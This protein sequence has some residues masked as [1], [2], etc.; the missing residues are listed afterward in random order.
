MSAP[1]WLQPKSE[2]E[3]QQI[4]A[5]LRER[6]HPLYGTRLRGLYLYGSYARGDAREG[7]DLDVLVILDRLE[8]QWS[9]IQRTSH[10][11]AA[12]SLDHDVSIAT[13]FTSEDR[14]QS[15]DSEFLRVVR[16][17]GRAA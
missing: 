15:A 5:E 17:E 2:A 16:E 7:S 4:L 8:S 1:S 12:V 9:E 3:V 11:N 10:E 14:W 13:I 6:F